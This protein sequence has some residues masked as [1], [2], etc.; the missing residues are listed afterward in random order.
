MGLGL[1]FSGSLGGVGYYTAWMI[2][3]GFESRLSTGLVGLLMACD[4]D[5]QGILTALTKSIDHPSSLVI[6]SFKTGSVRTGTAYT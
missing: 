1:I 2:S 6:V 5:L 4:E 3:G